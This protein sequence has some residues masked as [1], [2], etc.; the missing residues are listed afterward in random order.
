MINPQRTCRRPSSPNHAH[1]HAQ[2]KPSWA[3]ALAF[4]VC[5]TSLVSGA[6]LGRRAA[7]LD[8]CVGLCV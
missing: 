1:T 4:I 2:V 5:F 8:Q 3:Y 6:L 7:A